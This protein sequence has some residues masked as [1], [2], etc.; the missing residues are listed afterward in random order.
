MNESYCEESR[1]AQA[2]A[3]PSNYSRSNSTE[4][5]NQGW[6]KCPACTSRQRKFNRYTNGGGNL[7]CDDCGHKEEVESLSDKLERLAADKWPAIL[8]SAGI[9]GRH[10][11]NKAGPCPSC[12]NP[13]KK[14]RFDNKDGRGTW[15]CVCGSGNGIRLLMN[16]T[17]KSY[18]EAALWV[19]NYL[20]DP[21][22]NRQAI[23]R[24]R[25]FVQTSSEMTPEMI[26]HR[27]SMYQL[28]WNSSH[29]VQVDDPVWKYLTRR[30]PGLQNVPS[31]IR[32]HPGLEYIG[33]SATGSKRG[34]SYGVHPVMLCAVLNDEGIC[35]NLH[36]TYLTQD[37]EKLSITEDGEPL[38]V[39]KLMPSVGEKSYAIR[40]AK[41]QGILGVAEGVETALAAMLSKGV[42][43]WAVVSTSGMKS[44][45]VPEDVHELVIYADNDEL[46]RQ[47]KRPGFDAAIS[48]AERPDVVSRVRA[49]TLKV[50]VV[51]PARRGQDMADMLLESVALQKAA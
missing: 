45:N 3:Q 27:K 38:P 9:D 42:P 37:G 1:S 48:L 15:I 30:L 12:G 5:T 23:V 14:F 50:K 16:C 4:K 22:K 11:V 41:H 13:K 44:F 2:T 49:K 21:D 20:G 25:E 17:G 24:S 33:P 39:K 47:R 34:V 8:E 31:V 10:L 29:K 19:I 26:A 46:T 7:Q 40:L 28:I 6:G 35:C 36:R 43:T 32:F 18:I 51:T